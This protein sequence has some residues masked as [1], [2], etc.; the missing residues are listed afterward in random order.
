MCCIGWSGLATLLPTIG[1]G[2]FVYV[3]NARR[4]IFVALAISALGLTLSL[5]RHRRPWPLLSAAAGAGLLL[6][7]FYHALDVTLWLGMVYSGLALL[8][9]A[10]GLDGWLVYRAGRSCKVPTSRPRRK[11]Q[12]IRGVKY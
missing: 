7:P 9:V 5:R 10:A 11:L 8:V 2:Y 3:S 4:L 12:L 6:Y 1:F